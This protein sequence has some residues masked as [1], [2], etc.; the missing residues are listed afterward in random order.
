MIK[1]RWS[2]DNALAVTINPPSPRF[3]QSQT[4]ALLGVREE[5]LDALFL[6][7]EADLFEFLL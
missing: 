4:A 5:Q 2:V 1:S 7:F 6:H 3:V